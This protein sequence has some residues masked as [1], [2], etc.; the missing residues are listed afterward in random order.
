MIKKR[1]KKLLHIIEEAGSN[2]GR[3]MHIYVTCMAICRDDTKRA[4]AN[5]GKYAKKSDLGLKVLNVEHSK[6]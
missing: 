5:T 1:A 4:T 6:L 3:C 2:S